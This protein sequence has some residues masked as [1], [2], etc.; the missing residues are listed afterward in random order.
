MRTDRVFTRSLKLSS[1]I[2]LNDFIGSGVK[3][4][5]GFGV[6]FCSNGR[7]SCIID[8]AACLSFLS[9]CSFKI[10]HVFSCVFQCF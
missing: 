8:F 6:S 1:L 4:G 3:V 2:S 10:P 7:V 9:G 5:T